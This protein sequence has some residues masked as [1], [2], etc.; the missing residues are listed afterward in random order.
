MEQVTAGLPQG[1]QGS[2]LLG[3]RFRHTVKVPDTELAEQVYSALVA[4]GQEP[5]SCLAAAQ[6]AAHAYVQTSP[7][8]WQ[9]LHLSHCA[10]HKGNNLTKRQIPATKSVL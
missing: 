3:H 1:P 5:S 4:W 6:V 8:T 10:L 7:G 2:S 9:T